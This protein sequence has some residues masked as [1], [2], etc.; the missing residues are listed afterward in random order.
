MENQLIPIGNETALTVELL[1]EFKLIQSAIKKQHKSIS[2]TET[3]VGQK[4]KLPHNHMTY[5]KIGYMRRL[6]D[7]Q[8]PGWSWEIVSYTPLSDFAMVVHGRLKWLD[9]GLPR[10]G[11]M[12]AAHRI[13]K[14]SDGSGEYVDIGNDVKSANTDT[15]KKALNMYMNIA[16]DVYGNQDDSLTT[17]QM[18]DFIN[19]VN[20][21]GADFLENNTFDG[22]NHEDWHERIGNGSVNKLNYNKELKRMQV[23]L[24]EFTDMEKEKE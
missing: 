12:I 2:D 4:F 15:M 6:A 22:Y 24:D 23:Y 14:K 9:N 11:D 16:D 20:G 7:E 3:P 10:T 19:V 13:Q 21:I 1:K 5:V 18:A 17:E 8:F